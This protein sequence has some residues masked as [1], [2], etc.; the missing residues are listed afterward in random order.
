MRDAQAVRLVRAVQAV[1]LPV[2]G[3]K[4]RDAGAVAAGEL[5]A[6]AG[7]VGAAQLIAAVSAVVHTVAAWA[8]GVIG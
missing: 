6:A 5:G 7:V 2:T 8:G 3:E 4:V 1:A